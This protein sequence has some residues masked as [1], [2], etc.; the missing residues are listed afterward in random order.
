MALTDVHATPDA[1]EQH[2]PG[3]RRMTFWDAAAITLLGAA[4]FAF[5]YDALRQVAVAVHARGKLSYLFPVFVDGFIAYGVR[6]LVLLRHRNFGAR[7]YAW[8]LFLAA[9]AASLWANALHAVTLN[10]GPRSERSALHLGDGVVAVLSMLA[11]LALAGSV[12]LYIIMARTAEASVPDRSERRPGP[13]RRWRTP[14]PEEAQP[15]AI[16]PHAGSRRAAGG[17]DGLAAPSASDGAGPA[18]ADQE[19]SGTARPSE[20]EAAPHEHAGRGP[21]TRAVRD[22][23]SPGGQ[24]DNA[25][26]S[27]RTRTEDAPQVLTGNGPASPAPHASDGSTDRR[28]RSVPDAPD[29]G[30]DRAAVDDD[31]DELLPIAREA[32]RRAGRIS[33]SAIQDAVRAHRPISNDRLGELLARLREEEKASKEKKLSTAAGGLG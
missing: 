21:S 9:T 25:V 8:T 19:E 4:G 26:P 2:L 30:S 7:L 32:S 33:R 16:G 12:H 27:H 28:S 20:A 23:E 18:V 1:A 15:Q 24:A 5:S 3:L 17:G 31:L 14:G 11:P 22:G 6:A 10:H 29:G 13:V